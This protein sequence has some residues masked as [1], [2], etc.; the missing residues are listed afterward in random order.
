MKFSH[1]NKRHVRDIFT[2]V[3]HP[4]LPFFFDHL[5]E[6][7]RDLIKNWL[8]LRDVDNGEHNSAHVG[9]GPADVVDRFDA[10]DP[11]DDGRDLLFIFFATRQLNWLRSSSI[12]AVAAFTRARHT[13][14]A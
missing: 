13:W 5:D 10:T 14:G 6:L 7:V 11:F 12:S 2:V 9:A 8:R 3:A 4:S 1:Q